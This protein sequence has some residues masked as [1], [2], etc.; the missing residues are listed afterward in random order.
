M[1]WEMAACCGWVEGRRETRHSRP[2]LAG[3]QLRFAFFSFSSL[4]EV[5]FQAMVLL[6]LMQL[7]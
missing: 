3:A 5:L 4:V 6:Q 7:E 2:S 1:A